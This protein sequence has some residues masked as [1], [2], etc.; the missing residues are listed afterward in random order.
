MGSLQCPQA[1]CYVQS[2]EEC[3]DTH[4]TPAAALNVPHCACLLPCTLDSGFAQLRHPEACCIAQ[5]RLL[6]SC[7]ACREARK[8]NSGQPTLRPWEQVQLTEIG[9]E[10]P[11]TEQPQH[12][13][14]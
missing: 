3:T 11:A 1:C 9:V 8:I 2:S 4:T 13:P 14:G 10:P 12:A 7:A 5:P 6:L